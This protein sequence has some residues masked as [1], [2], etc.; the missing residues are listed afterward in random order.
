LILR[1]IFF[2]KTGSGQAERNLK[3]GSCF[4]VCAGE[5]EKITIFR[6]NPQG[7][8]AVKFVEGG[9]AQLAIEK[10]HRA[11]MA[12]REVTCEYFDNI[13]DYRVKE[14]E[15]KVQER[16][17]SFDDFLNEDVNPNKI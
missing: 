5:V 2:A 12:G 9:A 7:V 14:D 16:V 17:D 1:A 3:Q 4:T 11:K 8:V 15:K 13:T 6:D 10:M